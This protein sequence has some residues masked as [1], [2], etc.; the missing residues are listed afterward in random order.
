MYA[1]P[2]VRL[3]SYSAA[4]S[5]SSLVKGRGSEAAGLRLKAVPRRQKTAGGNDEAK[6]KRGAG[7]RGSLPGPGGRLDY[8]H[9]AG[10][11]GGF[12]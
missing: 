8:W 3:S 10:Q 1:F 11:C 9:R 5:R 6:K 2:E 12:Q 7:L 4:R